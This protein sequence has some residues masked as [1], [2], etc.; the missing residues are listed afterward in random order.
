MTR[1]IILD[2]FKDMHAEPRDID[3]DEEVS[4]ND[5]SGIYSRFRIAARAKHHGLKFGFFLY[6]TRL[7]ENGHRWGSPNQEH[8]AK[9]FE[10]IN[11]DQFEAI[12]VS[13][14]FLR[15]IVNCN[16]SIAPR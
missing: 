12:V 6:F 7:G 10:R 14:I 16:I 5:V 3:M 1:K 9:A 8:R 15:R 13:L 11:G 2:K 4:T